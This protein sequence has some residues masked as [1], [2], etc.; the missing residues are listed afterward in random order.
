MGPIK[1]SRRS[2]FLIGF[3]GCGK[4]T[5]GPRL[6]HRLKFDFHDTDLLI[7]KQCRKS[8]A[9]LFK[10]EGETRFREL[11]AEIIRTLSGGNKPMV[12][13]LGGGAFQKKVNRDLI[14]S[15]GVTVYL[16]CSVRKLARRLRQT[17][18][19]PLVSGKNMNEQIKSLLK[20][21][22][23]NYRKADLICSTSERSVAESVTR[24]IK[25]LKGFDAER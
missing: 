9:Q 25:L 16:S 13:A 8:I 14:A 21:R 24:L 18:D 22:V 10:E 23:H 6:A 19:R 17:T 20:Q 3:S 1:G 11:E 5:I 7:E 12:V 4:S 2:V 15:T